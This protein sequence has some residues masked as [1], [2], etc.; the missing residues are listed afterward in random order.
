[1]KFGVLTALLAAADAFHTSAPI[2]SLRSGMNRT[3]N[4]D[5]YLI[6]CRDGR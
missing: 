2:I 4:F 1:M 5:L 3:Y 6:V